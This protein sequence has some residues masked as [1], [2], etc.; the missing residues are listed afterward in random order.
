M[1]EE[2]P[3]SGGARSP[4][5]AGKQLPEKRKGFMIY[6]PPS[7]HAKLKLEAIKRAVSMSEVASTAVAQFLSDAPWREVQTPLAPAEPFVGSFWR[8][9]QPPKA[10]VAV[11]AA[12]VPTGHVTYEVE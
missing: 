11:P 2:T 5:P 4:R 3:G 9:Q 8:E 12:E 1:V 10:E 7:L 6:L